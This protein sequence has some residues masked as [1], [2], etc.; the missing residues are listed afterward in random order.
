MLRLILNCLPLQAAWPSQQVRMLGQTSP[1]N[2]LIRL[3]EA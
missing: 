2:G 1:W 3:L